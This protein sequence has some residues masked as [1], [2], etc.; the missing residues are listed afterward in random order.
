[1][2]QRQES[3]CKASD[4]GNPFM[5][6]SKQEAAADGHLPQVRK[7]R[8]LWIAYLKERSLPVYAYRHRINP[9]PWQTGRKKLLF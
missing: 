9:S 7:A 3:R 6:L 1:M 8:S 2:T 5:G 4:A